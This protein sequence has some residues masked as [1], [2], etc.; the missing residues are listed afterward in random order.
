MEGE[1]SVLLQGLDA[2]LSDVRRTLEF[3]YDEKADVDR[4]V[5]LQML[6][7]AMERISEVE[8]SLNAARLYLPSYEIRRL[9]EAVASLEKLEKKRRDEIFPKQKFRFRN[10]DK[11]ASGKVEAVKGSQETTISRRTRVEALARDKSVRFENR[12][13]ETFEVVNKGRD[14]V[15]LLGLARCTVRVRGLGSSL[16]L[17]DLEDCIIETD[18]MSGSAH[19]TRCNNCVVETACHQFRV[20]ESA[21]C[22]FFLHVSSGPI[23]ERCSQL[24]FSSYPP[25]NQGDSELADLLNRAL[26]T[27]SENRWREV[28]DFNWLKIQPSPNF[29]L[30]QPD[31]S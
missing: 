6:N 3:E 13:G 28:K 14:A 17:S 15:V 12:A 8:S 5:A 20:H 22:R 31:Q 4:V 23:I 19:L 11:V 9:V 30:I 25:A 18:P 29:A 7:E 27:P 24:Q 21:N 2:A 16:F 26:L 10:L 1:V